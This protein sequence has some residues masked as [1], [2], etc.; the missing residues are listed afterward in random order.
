MGRKLRFRS[1]ENIIAEFQ[2]ITD[3]IPFVKEI[4]IE[5]DTFTLKKERVRR[6][7]TG[8]I[9]RN[10]KVA[11]SCNARADLDY[12][13]LK[14]MK[15]AGCRL[16]IVGYESGSNEILQSIKKGITIEKAKVFTRDAKR[17][18]LLVHG[19][20]II[21]LPG[22]TERTAQATLDYIQEIKPDIIQVAVATPIPGTAFYDYVKNN[23]FLLVDDMRESIDNNGYQRCIISYPDFSKSDIEGWVNKIL[24]T[25][26]MSP[27]YSITVIRGAIRG[28]G[29]EHVSSVMR[30]G[31]EFV[32]YLIN[33]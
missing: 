21:G 29:I 14:L 27:M 28:G 18:G 26:Y 13:T 6:F 30:A 2:Y 5:D 33:F 24:K 15:K 20:F 17:A 32:K 8:L 1:V 16:I 12:E 22:E 19:D 3:S 11:W 31:R 7:C 4:F 10:I 25:Y 9:D 23:G